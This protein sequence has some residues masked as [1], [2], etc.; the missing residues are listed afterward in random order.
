MNRFRTKLYVPLAAKLCTLVA[1]G[2][3]WLLQLKNFS[4]LVRDSASFS[5]QWLGLHREYKLLWSEYVELD[6]GEIR[7]RW[8]AIEEKHLPI[9]ELSIAKFP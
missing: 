4:E 1:A 7:K 6:P 3:S 9:D 5:R 2:L 8:N